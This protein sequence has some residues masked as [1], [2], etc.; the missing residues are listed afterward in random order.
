MQGR[1]NLQSPK[2]A[3]SNQSNA[4][5]PKLNSVSNA[6]NLLTPNQLKREHSILR[7]IPVAN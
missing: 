6:P 4:A 2:S 1:Q 7:K 3:T 5:N